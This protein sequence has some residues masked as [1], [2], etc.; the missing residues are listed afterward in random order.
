MPRK[1][2][3]LPMTKSSTDRRQSKSMEQRILETLVLGGGCFWCTEAV[4]SMLKGVVAVTPGYAGG[5][6]VD[7]T[8]EEVSSG[9]TGHA[10]VIRIEYDLSLVSVRDLLA[11][12]F[13]THDPTTPDRQ[14]SDVGTQYR[15]VIF[16]TTEAQKAA[17]EAYIAALNASSADGATI[18]TDVAP[19]AEFYEAEAYHKDYFKTHPE[20]AYCQ[21]VIN[22]KLEKAKKEFAALIR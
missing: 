9:A 15:S 1:P 13:A 21:I 7:P 2:T 8:Y 6:T 10:E 17:A 16:Y 3:R 12:F 22:P 20:Q 5:A 11:V 4:F 14:G 19:L 18:V